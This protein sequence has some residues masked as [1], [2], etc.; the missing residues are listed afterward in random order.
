MRQLRSDYASIQPAPGETTIEDDEPVFLL[1]ARD[2]LAPA[3]VRYW[4]TLAESHGADVAM[5]AAARAWADEMLAWGRER[6]T[7]VPDVPK[8]ALA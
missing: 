7:H 3:T 1:R 6:G 5:V 4:A 2:T 8:G